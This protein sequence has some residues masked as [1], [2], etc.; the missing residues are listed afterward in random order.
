MDLGLFQP[1]VH[2]FSGFT[3]SF[4]SA[5]PFLSYFFL[6]YYFNI[7]L[8]FIL[9]YLLALCLLIFHVALGIEVHRLFPISLV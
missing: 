2:L 6:L 8:H 1:P 3:F 7:F 4:P 5:P 9:M